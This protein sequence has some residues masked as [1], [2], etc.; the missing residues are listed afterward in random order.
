MNFGML[1]AGIAQFLMSNGGNMGEMRDPNDIVVEGQR[2]V[3]NPMDAMAQE[4][5]AP[6]KPDPTITPFD[7]KGR[8]GTRGTLR[9]ILGTVGDAFLIQSGNKPMY[10][11]RRAQEQQADAMR[12]FADNPLKAVDAL[13]AA[14]YGDAAREVYN[15]YVKQGLDR[16][17]YSLDVDK[18]RLDA[19][20]SEV[21]RDTARSL[22]AQRGLSVLR[23]MYATVNDPSSLAQANKI[24]AERL[25]K[26][27]LDDMIPRLPKSVN[28]ATYWQMDP[29]RMEALEDADANRAAS[30]ARNAA[31][32]AGA[33]QRNA[34]T[35]AGAAARQN[36]RIEYDKTKPKGGGQRFKPSGPLPTPSGPA[37]KPTIKRW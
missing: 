25:R 35:I 3:R 37:G 28:E 27:G 14:G 32:I 21:T 13:V 8:F 26:L 20:N 2:S 1:P 33:N 16:D 15:D 10:A 5:S 34:A 18:Y 19:D 7:H 4:P 24:A 22:Q 29:A 17:K 12:G 36:Q 31:S 30:N 23:G 9:D 6:M 11:P